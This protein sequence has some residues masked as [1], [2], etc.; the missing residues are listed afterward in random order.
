MADP[1]FCWFGTKEFSATRVNDI[2]ASLFVVPATSL[3]INFMHFFQ[4]FSIATVLLAASSLAGAVELGDVQMRSHIGQ[5]LS[6]DIELIGA[7]S[8][9]APIQAG[10]ADADVYRGASLAMHPALAGANITTFRRD[11]R[12]YLHISSST[13]MKSDHLP[14]FFTLTENGQKSVRQVTL[15]LTADPNP[16]PPPAPVQVAAPVI[17]AAPVPVPVPVPAPAPAAVLPPKIVLPREVPAL[18]FIPAPSAVKHAVTLPRASSAPACS[19]SSADADSCAALDVKNAALTAHLS[20]LEDK[21][22]QLS[23]ALESAPAPAPVAAPAAPVAPATPHVTAPAPKPL[24]AKLVPMGSKPVEPAGRPWLVIGIVAAIVLSLVAALSFV[25]LRRRAKAAPKRRAAD[26]AA[27]E[28]A[29]APPKPS[30]ISNVKNRLMPGRAG[31]A[32]TAAAAAPAEE[33]SAVPAM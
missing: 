10:V 18:A 8:D 1:G 31:A 5:P 29:A 7:A 25:L 30:F 15:W 9:G 4:G 23:T 32:P 6:A 13:P 14:I 19:R 11:G 24:P 21:I 33:A 28:A 22:K 3:K 26:V 12:R 16:A 17:V 20:E 2:G 27:A